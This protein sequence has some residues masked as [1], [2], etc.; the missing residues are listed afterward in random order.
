M[1][2]TIAARQALGI[3]LMQSIK[4]NKQKV[5]T[6]GVMRV[7]MGVFDPILLISDDLLSE[8]VLGYAEKKHPIT[9][10]LP[11]AISS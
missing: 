7:L 11:R 8:P 4:K 2:M 10:Q 6:S 5:I 3:Y 9:E 1:T